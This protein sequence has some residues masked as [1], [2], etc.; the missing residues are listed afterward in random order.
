MT[1]AKCGLCLGPAWFVSMGC[2]GCASGGWLQQDYHFPGLHVPFCSPAHL[3]EK[4]EAVDISLLCLQQLQSDFLFL[5]LLHK[6]KSSVSWAV[7]WAVPNSLRGS[8]SVPQGSEPTVQLEVDLALGQGKGRASTQ[9]ENKAVCGLW[10]SLA[11]I[12]TGHSFL[13][14]RFS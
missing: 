13:H 3:V 8:S 6:E 11:H 1:T 12:L 7:M 9:C 2:P 4:V 10:G 5:W 14:A